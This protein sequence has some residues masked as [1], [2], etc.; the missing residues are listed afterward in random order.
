MRDACAK[1]ARLCDGF[2][3]VKFEADDR[4]P[5]AVIRQLEILGEAAGRV[6]EPSRQANRAVPWR[7]LR[8]LRNVLIHGYDTV[9]LDRVWEIA[10]KDVP[11]LLLSLE[12]MLRSL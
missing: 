9:A 10:V 3:Q 1:I 8:D 11:S 4:T 2:D 7:T 5:D 6:S 12:D